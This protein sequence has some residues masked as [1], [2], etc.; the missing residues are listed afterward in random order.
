MTGWIL[1]IFSLGTGL[2][3]AA[4]TGADPPDR[5]PIPGLNLMQENGAPA[6]E[7][8]AGP[9]APS[10]FMARF[11]VTNVLYERF[12]PAH[13]RSGLSGC[14]ACPVTR[15]TWPEANAFCRGQGGR[16]PTV[17]E[18]ETAARGPQGHVYSFGM[19]AD[20]GRGRFNQEFRA[21]AAAVDSL[22]P[23]GYG[24][25][26]MSGNVWEWVADGPR[27]AVTKPK[28][29]ARRARPRGSK[30]VVGGS[31]YSPAYYLQV[32]RRFALH[33]AARLN[34]LGFRCAWDPKPR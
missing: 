5:V 11:E 30:T 34:S 23:N 17:E 13:R 24:L 29:S 25:F 22:P 1:W 16:L 8:A 27:P 12:D 2:P 6:P 20:P 31:W 15:I 33:A 28:F 7:Q 18:W 32:G 21:G 26:H 14:D 4:A 9:A 19:A 3:A 10:F